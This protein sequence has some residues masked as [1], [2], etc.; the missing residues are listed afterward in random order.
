[1]IRKLLDPIFNLR[2]RQKSSYQRYRWTKKI[3]LGKVFYSRYDVPSEMFTQTVPPSSAKDYE[4]SFLDWMKFET[5]IFHEYQSLNKNCFLY[6]VTAWTALPT[7]ISM[8]VPDT[9]V[10]KQLARK[11]IM[12]VIT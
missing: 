12:K 10:A 3:L 6:K 4:P 7:F 2:W 8:T 5:H 1:M 11:L 9:T